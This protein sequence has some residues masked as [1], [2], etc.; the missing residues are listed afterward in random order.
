MK[1]RLLRLS[2]FAAA[3]GLLLLGLLLGL[4]QTPWASHVLLKQ[5]GKFFALELSAERIHWRLRSDPYIELHT[6]AVRTATDK[7][8]L[9]QAKRVLV[10]IPWRTLRRSTPDIILDRIEL[11][12]PHLHLPTLQHWL[13]SRPPSTD[14]TPLPT[15]THGL[16]MRDGHIENDDWRIDDLTLDIQHFSPQAPLLI[17]V[18]GRY[19]DT[20]MIIPAALTIRLESVA[21]LQA[22]KPTA[23][24]GR[25]K[26]T[27]EG[28]TWQLPMAVHLSGPL[29]IGK[30]SALLKPAKLG[31]AGH[32]RSG[33]SSTPFQLGLYGPMLFN[34]AHWRFVP[35]TLVLQGDATVP[36]LRARGQLA[37]GQQL[38][39]RLQG[40]MAQWPKAWPALPA[41]LSSQQAAYTFRLGYTGASDLSAPLDLTL[42]QH[43]THFSSTL[44]LP[45]VLTWLDAGNTAVL[46]PLQ[47]KLTT[48]Q[49]TLDGIQFEGVEVSLEP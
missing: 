6:L 34:N 31:L 25:G 24:L 5:A 46:P 12:A 39:L 19:I 45:E 28:D 22:H 15:V 33:E 16:Q 18:S 29:R 9:L 38:R 48:P 10:R 35:V 40:T 8:P 32:Y 11:D 20:P 47:G 37:V 21:T 13:T 4:L 23:I 26:L 3:V 14:E 27:V 30:D 44:R 1:R 43:A 36:T 41:P 7:Q 2:G 49:I 17:D 42:E